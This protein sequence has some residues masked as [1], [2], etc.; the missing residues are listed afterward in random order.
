MKSVEHCSGLSVFVSPHGFSWLL[1]LTQK[2]QPVLLWW[3]FLAVEYEVGAPSTCISKSAVTS[4]LF[5]L[6]SD[7][8]Y[9]VGLPLSSGIPDS[10]PG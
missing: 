4:S 3:R 1:L 8:M 7:V 6:S 2:L 5:T 10:H 9:S